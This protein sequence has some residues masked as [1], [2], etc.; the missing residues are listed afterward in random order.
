M[1]R[2]PYP[3]V[4]V[5]SPSGAASGDPTRLDYLPLEYAD[6]L[7]LER[8][9]AVTR[10]GRP[11]ETGDEGEAPDA[12]Q[13]FME[14][15]ALVA[16]VLSVYQRQFA[17]EAFLGTATAASSLVRHAHRLGYEPDPGL[18]ATGF[19]VLVAK[20]GV[21]GTVAAGLPLASVPL[22][23]EKAQDYETLADVIVDA[24]L[25]EL[26]PTN[27]S[28]AIETDAD[29]TQLVL[30]GTGHRIAVGDPVALVGS[31]AA[32]KSWAVTSVDDDALAGTT[33]IG[34]DGDVGSALDFSHPAQPPT[35]LA[36]PTLSLRL[37]A[38]DADPAVYDP[39]A[40]RLAGNSTRAG[41]SSST[42]DVYWYEVASYDGL[43]V[44]LSEQLKS[45]LVDSYLVGA[46][47]TAAPT[48]VY[49]VSDQ[50]SVALTL[51]RESAQPYKAQRVAVA[52]DGHG[53]FVS[54]LSSSD[55]SLT[56]K[57]HLSG[58]VTAL[59][60][61]DRDGRTQPRQELP[62]GGEWLAGWSDRIPLATREPND[63]ALSAPLLLPGDLTELTPGRPLVF[64]SLDERTVQVV[65]VQRTSVPADTDSP[66]TS[67][68][69]DD[70]TDP[71]AGGWRLDDLK[72]LGNVARVSHGRTVNETLG[73]SDGV[74]PFQRFALKQS[75][76]TILPS[77]AGGAPALEV[78]VGGVRWDAVADFGD[79]G[80]LDRHY[81]ATTDENH[82]TTVVFG[83]GLD[84]AVPPSGA[85][86]VT[87]S[88][89]VGLGA[90]GNVPAGRVTRLKRADPLLDRV[91]NVTPL[92]GGTDPA[93]PSAV[94]TQATRWI[95]TFDRA[96]STSDLAD[97]ALTMPGIFRAASRWDQ[98]TGATLVVAT[99]DGEAP[100]ELDVVRAF[101]DARRDTA[102]P[103][104]VKGP[105]P[106]AV[107]LD[108]AFVRDTAYPA[109][110]VKDGLRVALYGGDPARPGMFT[111]PA[112][113]LGQPAFLSEVYLRLEG[114]AGV[115]G[116]TV[117]TF[118][119]KGA[120]GLEH[121]IPA[122]VDEW[123]ELSPN[124]LTLTESTTGSSG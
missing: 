24:A 9:L 49:L 54:K 51:Q 23:T 100:P 38:A 53:G 50:K 34:L 74:T 104:V 114:V 98:A 7:A 1:S 40:L 81:R 37:F 90:A 10:L 8:Q 80:P 101:L 4:P 62:L 106:K 25:N 118:S 77:V 47:S 26:R 44:Y 103:L 12:A 13:T 124:D 107:C 58:T 70:L 60:L 119:S 116:V 75:P 19:V 71:P 52:P 65:T 93:D 39:A 78:R 83:D 97:L 88:Y 17:G 96:V 57:T 42:G 22:G 105:A 5:A 66:V 35:L 89:R 95:R 92:D 43:D 3:R 76:V 94:R 99:A 11:V 69:W 110:A 91:R 108:V 102:L 73:G 61:Q 63:T 21:R 6:L 112:R 45:S 123:L 120:T 121:V 18:A 15:S 27:A 41:T 14:L 30:Q 2:P 33:T 85:T 59:R 32:W 55:A 84:G 113:D 122:G 64:S 28:R 117:L 31:A 109:E 68:W 20:P 56:V 115:V 111:F 82:V 79:S 87:A 48:D 67:L 29:A 72:V 46:P 86:N 16:H 36:H